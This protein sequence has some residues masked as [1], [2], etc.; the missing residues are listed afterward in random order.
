MKL[1]LFAVL[2]SFVNCSKKE[3]IEKFEREI[4]SK[5]D[6]VKVKDTRKT[7]DIL[8][9]LLDEEIGK[10]KTREVDYKEYS[11]S[12]PNDGDSYRVNFSKITAEDFNKDGI[13]DFI[14]RRDSEGMLGGN[15]NTNAEILYIIMKSDSA[16]AQKHK[17]L[18]YAPFS[19]NILD[20]I[21]YNAGVLKANASQNY[22]TYS[23]DSILS[24]NL[25]FIYKNGNVYEKSYLSDCKLA[26]WKDKK[27][28]KNSS[29]ASR[30]IEL[31]NYT[32]VVKDEFKNNQ[33]QISAEISGC[34]NLDAVFEGEFKLNNAKNIDEKRK[35]FL[36]FIA[37]NT[38][39]QNE[40]TVV[41]DYYLQN[42]PSE[43]F[44]EYQDLSFKIFTEQKK[45]KVRFR[46]V[47]QSKENPNQTENW[48]ITTR[49]K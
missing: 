38:N 14:V 2:F 17:I 25:S 44:A 28:F 23:S 36:E 47:L 40:L 12:F 9:F 8:K 26:K 33:F 21:D 34:D 42:I 5:K 24:T 3:K 32:E 10:N 15:A 7:F 13:L 46:L 35:V 49:Q 11:A 1:I 43:N 19:Y 16:I 45:G 20:E 39:L 37:Q 27:V 41:K 31:H 6:S 29:L 22:R 30:T 18:I 48:Q 4:I